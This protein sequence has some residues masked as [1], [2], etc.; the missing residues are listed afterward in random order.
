LEELAHQIQ[1]LHGFTDYERGT[2]VNVGVASGGTKR[3]VVAAHAE[4]LIDLRVTSMAE[5]ERVVPLILDAKPHLDGASVTVSGELNR[6][7]MERSA[8]II[9]AFERAKEI[10]ASIGQELTEGSTG[11]GSDGNFTAALGVPT[12]D[13]LGCVGDGAH[14]DHEHIL[15]EHLQPR[16]ALITMLLASL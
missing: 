8:G 14:A 12:L 2:T 15:L 13:G 4:A 3:N 5:A 1:W 11:G 16:T 10:G 6:P 7:P 9:A